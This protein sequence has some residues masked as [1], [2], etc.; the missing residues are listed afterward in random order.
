MVAKQK[1]PTQT[2]STEGFSAE[3][4]AS[5]EVK[6]D[7][8]KLIQLPKFQ[9]FACEQ[10]KL[11]HTNVTQWI[12]NFVR[13]KIQELGDKSFFNLYSAWHSNKHYWDHETVYGEL[14]AGES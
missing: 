1:P 6:V 10:A 13:S 8:N 3:L 14:L 2:V 7:W 11:S 5:D 4:Y 9:M 12:P